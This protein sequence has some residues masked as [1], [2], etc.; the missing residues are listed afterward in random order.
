MLQ[1]L[2]RRLFKLAYGIKREMT[3]EE[4]KFIEASEARMYR[5]LILILLFSFVLEL[6]FENFLPGAVLLI[7]IYC[8]YHYESLVRK[9]NLDKI[10]VAQENLSKLRNQMFQK[11]LYDT[12]KVFLLT[13][14]T[15]GLLWY[16][17]IPQ[18]NTSFETYWKLAMPVTVLLFTVL[19][20]PVAY[21]HN[22]N[23]LVLVD[24]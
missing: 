17:Q 11:S 14:G 16:S 5:T 3:A 9:L 24:E 4:Q 18:Q 23:K 21:C 12:G 19:A 6:F 2:Y 8:Y 7:L 13:L 20:F 1:K 22:R 10:F 15:G